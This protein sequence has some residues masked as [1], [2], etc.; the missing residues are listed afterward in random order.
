MKRQLDDAVVISTDRN[1]EDIRVLIGK[2]RGQSDVYWE[3][4]NKELANRHLLI[5]GTSGQGKTYS[6]QTMLYELSKSNVSSVIFDYTEGFRPEQLEGN[7]VDK[8]GDH[9]HQRVCKFQKVPIIRSRGNMLNFQE[10]NIP[11]KMLI[12]PPDLQIS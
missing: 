10:I 1:I 5:T 8:M 6:I 11:K 3:F 7:F 2:D 12:L 4:G 9:I